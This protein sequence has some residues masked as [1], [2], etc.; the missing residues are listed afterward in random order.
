MP[1]KLNDLPLNCSIS[2]SDIEASLDNSKNV[3]SI[4]P[5]WL[6]GTYSILNQLL[7]FLYGYSS[8][9][10]HSLDE[11]IFPLIWKMSSVTPDIQIRR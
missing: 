8:V 5:D 3:K 2:I 9:F 10:H 11:G 6:S 7:P 1:F 4:C